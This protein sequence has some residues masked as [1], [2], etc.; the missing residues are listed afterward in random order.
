M[1]VCVVLAAVEEEEEAH[2]AL[3]H[4]IIHL[5]PRKLSTSWRQD[6]LAR[7]VQRWVHHR[8]DSRG[9]GGCRRLLGPGS[10][11]LGCEGG[12]ARH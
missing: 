12:C 11:Q 9:R 4:L 3:R 8:L 6:W 5:P 7:A 2:G 10:D 1:V